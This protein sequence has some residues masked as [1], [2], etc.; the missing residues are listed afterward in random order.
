M[1]PNFKRKERRTPDRRLYAPVSGRTIPLN[2]VS[3]PVYAARMYGEGIALEPAEDLICAPSAGTLCLISSSCHAFGLETEA[4]KKSMYMSDLERP[5]CAGKALKFSPAKGPK[6]NADSR[7]CAWTASF[8]KC[9][10]R[11]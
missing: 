5:N 10:V 1:K 7:F 11:I 3:D 9:A 2:L 4:G 6:L 8:S